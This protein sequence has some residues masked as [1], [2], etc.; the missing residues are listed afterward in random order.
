MLLIIHGSPVQLMTKIPS[1]ASLGWYNE[2]VSP[3]FTPSH[4][5]PFV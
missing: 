5:D 4:V 3:G 2:V 1:E